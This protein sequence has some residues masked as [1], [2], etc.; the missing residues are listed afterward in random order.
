MTNVQ[1]I[2]V[3]INLSADNGVTWFT[4]VCLSDHTIPIQ[5]AVN[6]VNTQCGIAAG[7]GPVEFNPTFQGVTNITEQ[8]PGQ[9]STKTLMQWVAAQTL[10]KY[11]CQQSSGNGS[12]GD[13]MYV[14][15]M[16][17]L[18]NITVTETVGD[19]EKFSG[20]LTGVGSPSLIPGT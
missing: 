7:L 3:L 5:S 4:I 9:A 8:I 13:L 10:L 19:V 20:T 2:N 6:K 14:S 15:G 17:Y 12:I 11:R 16:C 1:A 18:T